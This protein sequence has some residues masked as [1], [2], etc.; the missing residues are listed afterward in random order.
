MALDVN[1]AAGNGYSIKRLKLNQKPPS[2]VPI[3][4]GR[5]IVH[6][7]LQDFSLQSYTRRAILT[8]K[9]V[10]RHWPEKLSAILCDK[11][12]L[13]IVIPPGEN[14]KCLETLHNI[15]AVLLNYKFDRKSILI[16]AGG[17]I[18]CDTGAFAAA[19]YMRGIPFIQ[20]PTTL[21]SQTDAAIGGK[22]GVNFGGLK[23]IIG[24][25]AQP[26]AVVCD[27]E[28][29]STLPAREYRS[30][31]A[32]I[33]KHSLIADAGMFRKLNTVDLNK[34]KETEIQK[35][36]IKSCEIK[37][38]IVSSDFTEKGSRKLLNFGHTVGH[39]LEM[40]SGKT[41]NPLLHGEAVAIGMIAEAKLS[42]LAGLLSRDE[43]TKIEKIIASAQLPLRA[44]R[45]LLSGVMA[46][47]EQDKKNERKKIKWVLLKSIGNAIFDSEQPKQLIK[48]ALEY[49]LR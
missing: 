17:G 40:A 24:V 14:A 9:N 13:I 21:L 38:K 25:F 28:F 30:G 33:I 35:I 10:F 12:D 29:L 44:P 22:T 46:G 48:E 34:L 19:T 7:G 3:Y 23:N 1:S 26:V 18:V 32:E 31:F 4:I 37:C 41:A 11:D 42:T 36:L 47:M 6:R 49:V 27:T 2:D 15:W 8:D 5:G 16:N 45:R 43:L 20:L 39:A